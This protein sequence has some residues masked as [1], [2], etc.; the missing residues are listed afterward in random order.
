MFDRPEE[1]LESK[2]PVLLVAVTLKPGRRKIPGARQLLVHRLAALR[3]IGAGTPSEAT[4]GA[5]LEATVWYDEPDVIRAL[6]EALD[7]EEHVDSYEIV[8]VKRP[9]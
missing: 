4:A 1:A 8:H 7:T 5:D 9:T 3:G 2:M 6:L